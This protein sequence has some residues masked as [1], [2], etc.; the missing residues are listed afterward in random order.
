MTDWLRSALKVHATSSP[1]EKKEEKVAPTFLVSINAVDAAS[2]AELARRNP[3]AITT[4]VSER[5]MHNKE[6]RDV[7]REF[8][9]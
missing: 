9:R 6:L 2:F 4:V 8:I 3:E 5:M 1:Q 7:M